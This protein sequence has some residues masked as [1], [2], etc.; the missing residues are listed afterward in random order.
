MFLSAKSFFLKNRM[1]TV[2]AWEASRAIAVAIVICVISATLA[3]PHHAA[4]ADLPPLHV[5]GRELVAEGKPVRLRGLDWGWWHLSK[6]VYTENDMRRQAAWGANVA[7]LVFS[8]NDL[9][10]EDGTFKEDGFGKFDEVVQWAR[11]Y[12]QYV[13]FDMHVVPGGQSTQPYTAG[14][15]NR[16]WTDPVSREHYLTLWKEIARRYRNRPEVA[17]YE[18][19]NEPN[20]VQGPPDRLLALYREVIPAIRAVDPAKIIV[21]CGDHGSDADFLVDALKLPD[22]NILYTFHFYKESTGWVSNLD[23]GPGIKG[24]QDWTLLEKTFTPPPGTSTI[25]VLLRSSDNSGS[26]WFDDVRIEDVTGRHPIEYQDFNT[27]PK[28]FQGERAPRDVVQYDPA[29]GHSRPGSLRVHGTT[30]YNGWVGRQLRIELGHTYHASAWVKLDN[31]TGDTYL[32][33][34]F[35]KPTLDPAFLREKMEPAVTF[36]KKFNVP[37]WVGEFGH[38][39]GTGSDLEQQEKWVRACI[40]LFEEAG[41]SWTYWN[42]R[43]STEPTSMALQAE[44]HEGGDYPLIRRFSAPLRMAG[45][46]ISA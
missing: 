16:V 14:G 33:T 27:G 39:A 10:N 36:A 19:M 43:E 25:S 35:Y 42:Y 18:L 44:R 8:Y 28:V 3:F 21:V 41:F 15:K 30:G 2:M 38:Q 4:A 29:T 17:A 46:T 9:Q 32:T 40:R 22:P 23:N 20:T 13:I 11:K 45:S 5:Q 12:G 1:V 26:A 37:V 34:A 7:R 31:A 6:T 24:T